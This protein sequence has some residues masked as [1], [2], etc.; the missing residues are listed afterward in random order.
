MAALLLARQMDIFCGE[1][2]RQTSNF[3]FSEHHLLKLVYTYLHIIENKIK[4]KTNNMNT[5]KRQQ[6]QIMLQHCQ[7][8]ERM[9]GM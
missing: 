3:S 4:Y 8:S 7:S 9:A 1:R 6:K 2:E 5:L